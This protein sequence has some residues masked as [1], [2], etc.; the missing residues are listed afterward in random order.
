MCVQVGVNDSDAD[1]DVGYYERDLLQEVS[2]KTVKCRSKSR[3]EKAWKRNIRKLSKNSGKI[4]ISVA[5]KIVGG[6]TLG[7]GCN[8]S[9]CRYECHEKFDEDD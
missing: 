6:K 9:G 4:Y 3:N 1:T 5:G 2:D 8:S 7:A